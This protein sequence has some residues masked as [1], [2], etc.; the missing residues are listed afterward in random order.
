LTV[1]VEKASNAKAVAEGVADG[2]GGLDAPDEPAA[3]AVA[4]GHLGPVRGGGQ[5]VGDAEEGKFEHK[6]RRER[7]GAAAAVEAVQAGEVE[8]FDSPVKKL[9]GKP[10]RAKTRGE[11]GVTSLGGKRDSGDGE[12]AGVG[13]RGGRG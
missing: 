11:Q 10:G 13:D 2:G 6:Q 1:E 9:G 5:A 7:Q 8:Q 12:G 3:G 4:V